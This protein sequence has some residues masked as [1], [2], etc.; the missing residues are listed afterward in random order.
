[1]SSR[2]PVVRTRLALLS[3]SVRSNLIYRKSKQSK[4]FTRLLL[5]SLY[6][7]FLMK[8]YRYFHKRCALK[9]TKVIQVAF[10]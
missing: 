6:R 10:D 7:L 2:R 9:V 8:R 4:E 3:T 5:T 1:M